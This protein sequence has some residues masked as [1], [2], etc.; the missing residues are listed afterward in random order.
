MQAKL[1]ESTYINDF[2]GGIPERLK[3]LAIVDDLLLPNS[4]HG[5]LKYLKDLLKTLLKMYE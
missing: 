3:Y 2:L 5:H 4:K 1:Y